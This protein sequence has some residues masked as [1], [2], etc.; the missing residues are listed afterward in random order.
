VIRARL[1]RCA[2]IDDLRE[3]ARRALPRLAFDYLEG[4]AGDA[5]ALRRNRAALDAVTLTPRVLVDV[6]ARDTS[7]ELFGRRYA[8]PVGT[9][10]VGLMNFVTAG[11]DRDVAMA[12][13]ALDLPHALSTA[14]TTAIERL[15]PALEGRLWFQLYMPR[16]RAVGDDLLRRAAAAGVTVLLLTVDVPGPGRRDRDLRNGFSLPFRLDARNVLDFAL[17]PRWSLAQL[18]QG[19]PRLENWEPYAAG[20]LSAPSLA[21]LQA[22]QIDPSLDWDAAARL[23]DRWPGALVLKGILHPE[24]ASRAA[25]L[26]VDG[27][28]VSNHGG[29]QLAAAPAPIEVVAA[30]RAAIGER[31]R[32]GLDGGLRSGVD[33][34]RALARGA[35]FCLLGRAPVYGAAAFGQRG[36]EHALRIVLD[37]LSRTMMMLGASR[38][39]DLRA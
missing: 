29:R 8:A 37:D 33:V 2:S 38:L 7:I 39:A 28:V 34:A 27:V 22:E 30:I 4:G 13:R 3:A 9:A 25:A 17:H 26:G 31:L 1:D 32:I 19:A 36:A 16:D 18:R 5:A 35:D 24:D 14:A 10:P 23:R 21:A 11:G 20:R 15:A 6:A 12:A